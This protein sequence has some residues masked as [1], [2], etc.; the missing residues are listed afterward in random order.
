[1]AGLGGEG[2][3]RHLLKLHRTEIAMAVDDVFP[4]PATA[5]LTTT[6]S[7]STSSRRSGRAPT[8]L[9]TRCSP[10]CWAVTLPPSATSGPSSSRTTTWR[11]T[12]PA[13]GPLRGAFPRGKRGKDAAGAG[14]TAPALHR[15]QGKRKAPEERDGAR[16]VQPLPAACP[17]PRAPGEDEKCEEA[18]GR[19]CPP[20]PSCW[21]CPRLRWGLAAQPGPAVS[22]RA[23][24]SRQL[25]ATPLVSPAERK[26]PDCTPRAGCRY[27]PCTARTPHPTRRMRTSVRPCGDGGELICCDGLPQG[28]PPRLLGAPRCPASP[29]GT[30]RCGSCVGGAAEPGQLRE[31][32]A[33]RRPRAA[34]GGHVWHPG[35]RRDHLR[36]LFHPTSLHLGTAPRLAGTPGGCCSAH[37]ARATQTQAASTALPQPETTRYRQPSCR[38]GSDAVPEGPSAAVAPE[39]E[40]RHQPR[41]PRCRQRTGRKAA[42]CFLPQAEHI[43]PSS[44]PA[45]SRDELDALLGEGAWDGILHWAF[46]N[47][48]RPLADTHGL[49]A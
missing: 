17:Q 16:A 13:P 45:L 44:E 24:L 33:E 34:R 23:G 1:M 25:P 12:H 27:P 46:Q 10:G 47:M 28:L 31:A 5:W 9:S 35:R 49:F 4:L 20:H 8:A 43:S 48:A 18:G 39:T 21:C 7:P 26:S 6:S 14:P 22:P 32:A 30:W 29:A 36:P 11:G 15:P 3:L 40:P 19:G 2:D 41:P 42:G 37:P 38:S